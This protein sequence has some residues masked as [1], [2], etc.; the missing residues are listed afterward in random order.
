MTDPA[1]NPS[2]TSADFCRFG[3]LLTASHS[4]CPVLLTPQPGQPQRPARHLI[5]LSSSR[6]LACPL[7]PADNFPFLF[8]RLCLVLLHRRRHHNL[9]PDLSRVAPTRLVRHCGRVR[10]PRAV[11]RGRVREDVNDDRA[12][13][14]ASES[15]PD[16][17]GEDMRLRAT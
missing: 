9:L 17:D 6:L 7:Q 1:S 12:Q 3:F 2:R 13:G 8:Q 15:K 10:D 14:G 16:W 4:T 5:S 11:G